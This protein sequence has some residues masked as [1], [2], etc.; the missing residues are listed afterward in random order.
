MLVAMGGEHLVDEKGYAAPD[1][2]SRRTR[3]ED[4]NM[5][6]KVNYLVFDRWRG[7]A[8]IILPILGGFMAAMGAQVIWPRDSMAQMNDRINY[9]T[10]RVDS[11]LNRYMPTIDRKIDLLI[12][13]QCRALSEGERDLVNR[14]FSCR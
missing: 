12:R 6:Q 2:H 13:L 4:R 10:E 7:W 8:V 5:R 9:N 1:V 3:E 14:D 11:L